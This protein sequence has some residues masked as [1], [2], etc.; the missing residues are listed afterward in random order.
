[1]N[2]FYPEKFISETDV[3]QGEREAAELERHLCMAV[4]KHIPVRC[5]SAESLSQDLRLASTPISE[6]R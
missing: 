4:A 5:A 2:F 1:M 3:T 6:A